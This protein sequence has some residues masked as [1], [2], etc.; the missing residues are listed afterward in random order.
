MHFYHITNIKTFL[1][2]IGDASPSKINIKYVFKKNWTK[3]TA[4]RITTG[5]VQL[6]S[7]PLRSSCHDDL[8]SV[9]C[10]S[11]DFQNRSKSHVYF[12]GF[13]GFAIFEPVRQVPNSKSF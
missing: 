1:D 4:L 11:T 12:G 6:E 3:I 9:R 13:R 7:S 10:N 2:K 5:Q 8:P